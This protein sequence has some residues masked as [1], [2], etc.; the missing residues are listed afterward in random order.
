MTEILPAYPFLAPSMYDGALRLCSL[1]SDLKV[2]FLG[3]AT[4]AW[5]MVMANVSI[6]P[7]FRSR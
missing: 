2:L 5:D 6:L 7:M 4:V 3:R 1:E